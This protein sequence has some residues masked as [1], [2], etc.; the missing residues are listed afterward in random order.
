MVGTRIFRNG[1]EPGKPFGVVQRPQKLRD[2]LPAE[3]H[4]AVGHQEMYRAVGVPDVEVRLERSQRFWI[5]TNR[6]N[7]D[8]R[9]ARMVLSRLLHP[10]PDAT[11]DTALVIEQQEWH[12]PRHSSN[13]CVTAVRT[14]D[15]V[16]L[17]PST[18]PTSRPFRN[19]IKVGVTST[20]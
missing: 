13:A 7:D 11:A 12:G 17:G 20:P 4:R 16:G 6:S 18:R 5:V 19:M 3:P 9:L 1:E 15:I 8:A 14:L 10:V 2:G